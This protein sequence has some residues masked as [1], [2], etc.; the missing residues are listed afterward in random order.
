MKILHI[1]NGRFFYGGP[2][3][4]LYLCSGLNNHGIENILICHPE[5]DLS[6]IAKRHDL[7]VIELPCKGDLDLFF[8]FRLFKVIRN[9]KPDIIHCH[10]RRGGDYLGGIV[11]HCLNIPAILS[12]RVDSL[13]FN[14]MTRL[15]HALFV[16]I[17]AISKNI[18]NILSLPEKYSH[19][20]VLIRSAVDSQRFLI[21]S[22]KEDFLKKFDLNLNDF[23]I[24]TAG[25]LIPR[26]DHQFLITSVANLRKLYPQIKLIV[27]GRGQLNKELKNQIRELELEDYVVLA[28]FDIELDNYLSHFDLLVHPANAEG[29]G[30]ILMKA[31]AAGLP[32]VALNT[33]GISEVIKNGKTGLLAEVGDRYT[34]ENH[35][36]RLICSEALRKE[37]SLAAKEHIKMEF[38]LQQ[39]LK[40]HIQLYESIC[41]E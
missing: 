17:I 30:V 39:M 1:E 9:E 27:F 11:A 23:V 40:K 32:V 20:L 16:K 28:G 24:V 18:Y 25:Q 33:G 26:K 36:G 5:S 8:A 6:K 21:T 3:Q 29:L 31:G 35:I 15:R 7:R 13:E 34:F 38:S 2:Q 10:S 12:R 19:K 14:F 22:K 37:F 4:V 41:N